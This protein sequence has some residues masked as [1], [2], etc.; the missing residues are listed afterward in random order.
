MKICLLLML[1]GTIVA[2]SYVPVRRPAK[3]ATT[4]P[5]EAV[6]ALTING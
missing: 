2:F 3:T 4:A 6:A 1:I 5:P